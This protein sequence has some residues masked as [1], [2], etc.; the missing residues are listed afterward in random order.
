VKA[1]QEGL[2]G[3]SKEDK[4]AAGKRF[5]EARTKL[6]ALLAEQSQID[7][8][9]IGKL[10][11]PGGTRQLWV[12]VI[13]LAYSRA[14][15]AELVLDLSASSLRRSLVRAAAYFGGVTRQWLFD[16][17]KTVVLERHGDAVRFHPDL[18]ELENVVLVPHLGSATVETR[19]AMATLAARNAV[20]VIAGEPPPTPV[21]L[22]A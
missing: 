11:F 7:W 9:Y 8:G 5:N 3:I 20:A 21:P 6:E 14:M 15:W 17:P 12:F 18:L 2:R 16:N 4:P 22:P 19:E 10:R 13:V 1:L